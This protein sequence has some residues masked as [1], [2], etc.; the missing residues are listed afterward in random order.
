MHAALTSAGSHT[1]DRLGEPYPHL[2][3]HIAF[4]SNCSI[5][6]S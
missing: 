4:K 5:M 1:V 3:L 2:Q 6:L